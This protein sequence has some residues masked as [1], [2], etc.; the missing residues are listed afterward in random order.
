MAH[1]QSNSSK[2]WGVIL[3]AGDGVRLRPLTRF[4]CHDE[5]PKQFC[6][7]YGGTTLLEQ[8][9]ERA[10]QNIPANQI[11]FSLSRAHEDFYRRLLA[12]CPSQRVV[13]P[14]NRGTVPAILTS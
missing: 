13:Q 1:S 11:L 4:I 14:R 10:E 3:A 5:R 8:A 12:D 2:R 7:L 6:P 9:R